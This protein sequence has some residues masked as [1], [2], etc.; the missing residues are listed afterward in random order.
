MRVL[1]TTAPCRR[2]QFNL[3]DMFAVPRLGIGYLASYVEAHSS[4]QADILDMMAER[5]WID[6]LI[7]RIR[8]HGP[9]DVLAI[10]TTVMSMREAFE[11]A[12]LVKVAFPGMVTVVGGTGVCFTPESLC[13]YGTHVDYFVRGEGELPFLSLL[14]MLNGGGTPEA[15]PQLIWRT[16]EGRVRENPRGPL[17][18]LDDGIFCAYD[19]MPMHK[20]KLHPPHGIYPYATIMEASRGCPY[21]CDFCGLRDSIRYRSG[22]NI[23][24]EIRRLQ[25]RYKV[26]EVYFSDP[27]FGVHRARAIDLAERLG[28]LGIHWSA[29]TRVDRIDEELAGIY[30][31]NGCYYLAFGVESGNNAILAN[32]SKRADTEKAL[33]AFRACRSHRIRTT[34]YMM[35]GNPGETDQTVEDNIRFVRQLQPDYVLYG[36]LLPEPSVGLTEAA[37]AQGYFTRDDLDRY[38]LTDEPSV[39]ERVT[40]SGHTV[41]QANAWL[42]RASSDFYLR[43]TYFWQRIRDL[44]TIQ[45]AVNLGIGGSTFLKDFFYFGKLWEKLGSSRHN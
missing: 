18:D 24:Q 5:I 2:L 12:R 15:I 33:A 44:R 43:P 40:A 28:R 30:A 42:K 16:V 8:A 23:E 31:R 14:R 35:V 36:I 13:K 26:R 27:T 37:I 32:L 1:L 3:S 19:K 34:A 45:D 7:Q 41:D 6:G 21:P 20:Y 22:E 4:Y 25:S 39:L 38:L 29:M 17:R 10:G 11:M 9:Y